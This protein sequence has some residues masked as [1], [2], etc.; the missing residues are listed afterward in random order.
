MQVGFAHSAPPPPIAVAHLPSPP[1]RHCN[2][3]VLPVLFPAVF[4][5]ATRDPVLSSRP[6]DPKPLKGESD[7]FDAHLAYRQP[8]FKA[9]LCG[10]LKGPEAG[11]FAERAWTLV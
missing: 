1:P 9:N 5:I 10:Q 4:T 11:F 8:V 7:G 2:Q 3:H 6:S